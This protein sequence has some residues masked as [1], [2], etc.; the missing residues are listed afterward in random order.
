MGKDFCFQA[1]DSNAAPPDN[2]KH[3]DKHVKITINYSNPTN[4]SF[5]IIFLPL[6]C[7]KY[8]IFYI[9]AKTLWQ[10]INHFVMFTD[11]K[12]YFV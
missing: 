6:N 7:L 10:K 1:I 12:S 5:G 8:L 3:V 2:E 9:I 11:E 4:Q